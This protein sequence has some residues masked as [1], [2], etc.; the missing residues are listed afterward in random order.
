M[1]KKRAA[2]YVFYDKT[3]IVD[4]YVTYMLQELHRV[5][6]KVV[7]VCNG[8]LSDEGR[9]ALDKC[10]VDILVRKNVG[11]D[12]WGYKSGIDFIGWDSLASF[13]ELVLLND[14]VFGPIYPFSTMFDMM[15]E[16]NLDFWGITKHGEF[17][18]PDGLTVSGVFSEHIQSYFYAFGKNMLSHVDFRKYWDNLRMVKSWNEAVSYFESK[19]T[20]HFANLGFK[21]DVYVNTD[22]ELA[23]FDDVDQML[24]MA[25][26]M[27]R[28]YKSPIIKR[29]NFSIEFENFLAFSLGN[30]TKKAFDYIQSNT[31]YDVNLIWEHILRTMSLRHIVDNL[32]LNYVLPAGYVKDKTI[33]ESNVKVALFAHITFED[34][35]P[36][37][38]SYISTV[39]DIADVYITTLDKKMEERIIKS[40]EAIEDKLQSQPQWN[41]HELLHV[42]Q[43]PQ[44]KLLK[45]ITLP[46][47]SKGRDVGA[48]WVALKPYME[49]YDYICFVHN[50]K[51]AQDKPLTIGRGF[52]ERCFDNTLASEEFV[53]NIINQFET[54]PRLGM[55]FP[56]PVIHGPY[57][58]LISNL[59]GLNYEN[60]LKLAK[61]LKINVP[62]SNDMD[63]L[64][65]TG[66]MFWFRV[67]ALKKLIDYDFKY[68]DFPD[69]PLPV[70]G[71]LG[72]AFERI[73]CYA[74][75]SEGYYSAW[76][77]ND[78]AISTELTSLNYILT[79]KQNT[80]LGQLRKDIVELLR[81]SPGLYVFLR[82]IYRFFKKMLRKLRVRG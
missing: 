80:V 19:L 8:K 6:E 1:S 16:K 4:S 69:E 47:T 63:P 24:Q 10:A 18:N 78:N 60:T 2:V 81:K 77:M 15:G 65:P 68:D 36:F 40:F 11:F 39:V 67:N 28:D 82:K 14:S 23:E 5:C 56:P 70:D 71:S 46:E 38:M 25:F 45:V 74:A 21:W 52:A 57:Q 30:N 20:M 73:Y 33:D 34:Q 59:W 12:F 31:E 48:L 29:K 53:A 50:K 62:I 79:K 3:G 55:M 42:P 13:D 66:G 72:H 35:I 44:H 51:S 7:V 32:Q 54:S 27:V 76:L 9:Q 64:F 58:Y 37:C 43:Q 17:E 22:A 41:A 75:Q 61:Q 26:E 49:S